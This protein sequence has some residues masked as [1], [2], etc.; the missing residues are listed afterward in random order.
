MYHNGNNSFR[1]LVELSLLNINISVSSYISLLQAKLIHTDLL[2]LLFLMCVIYIA[3]LLKYKD[4]I[5]DWQG[6]KI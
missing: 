1:M 5:E 4:E 3:Y 2:L 6:T